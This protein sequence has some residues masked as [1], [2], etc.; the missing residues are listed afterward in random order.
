MRVLSTCIPPLLLVALAVAVARAGETPEIGKVVEDKTLTTIDG[1]TVKLSDY[2]NDAKGEGGKIVVLTFWSFK[3]P[4]GK[5]L[6]GENQALA[7]LCKKKDAVF[8][9]ISS[10]GESQKK[11]EKYCGDNEITYAVVYDGD[12][13]FAKAMDAQCVSTTAVIDADGKLAYYGCLA[14]KPD[15]KTGESTPHARK[16]VEELAAGKKVS[17]PETDVFG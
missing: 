10:Y 5:R 8:L 9:A 13:S 2:R 4:T 15:P 16:A 14:S 3:C 7:D 12:R 6:M 11:V 17:H 1:K